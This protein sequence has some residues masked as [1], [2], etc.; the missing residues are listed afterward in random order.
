MRVL[1]W[2]MD[3]FGYYPAIKNLE[4]TSSVDDGAEFENTIVAFIHGE[5]TDEDD[6]SKTETKLV[7][8]IKWLAGKLECKNIVL[9]SFAHLGESKCEPQFLQEL[10]DRVETRLDNTGYNVTQTPFGYF[11]DIKIDAPGKSLARVYKEF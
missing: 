8:N 2:Y 10:F 4:N 3:H 7:K 11:L 5:K 9:H 1:F 6:A